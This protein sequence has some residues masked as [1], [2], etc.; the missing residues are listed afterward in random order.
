M[1]DEQYHTEETSFGKTITVANVGNPKG[2]F[3]V[4]S[5]ICSVCAMYFKEDKMTEYK[6]KWYG[7]PCGCYG[8]IKSLKMKERNQKIKS[9]LPE[10]IR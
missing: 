10:E 1:R 3:G 6:G 4:R 5:H 2:T 9:R 7:I 8:D